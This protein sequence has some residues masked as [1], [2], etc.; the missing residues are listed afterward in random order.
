[1]NRKVKKVLGYGLVSLMLCG[2]ALVSK[3]GAEESGSIQTTVQFKN[4]KDGSQSVIGK[5][6]PNTRLRIGYDGTVETVS[7]GEGNYELKIPSGSAFKNYER[8]TIYKIN[9]DGNS[10]YDTDGVADTEAPSIPDFYLIAGDKVINGRANYNDRDGN[11]TFKIILPNGDTK[12]T[13]TDSEGRW[14]FE[15]PDVGPGKKIKIISSDKAGN[16]FEK[17]IVVSEVESPEVRKSIQYSPNYQTLS[18]YTYPNSTVY[19]LLPDGTKLSAETGENN[20]YSINIPEEHYFYKG[21][22][23]AE[24]WVSK[25]N[26]F[27]SNKVEVEGFS[28]DESSLYNY[29][30]SANNND[31]HIKRDGSQSYVGFISGFYNGIHAKLVLPD[32]F[33]I[34]TRTEDG[35]RVTFNIPAKHALKN[36]EKGLVTLKS[37][38]G[39]INGEFTAYIVPPELGEINSLTE[40]SNTIGGV[41]NQHIKEE[42]SNEDKSKISLIHVT[43]P[44]G[45]KRLVEPDRKG[46][47]ILS[48]P[49]LKKG[50]VLKVSTEDIVGNISEP[51]IIKVG[52]TPSVVKPDSNNKEEQ[53]VDNEQGTNKETGEKSESK[54]K[55][56]TEVKPTEEKG[57]SSSQT[58]K[59]ETSKETDLKATDSTF[60]DKTLKSN[61][62]VSKDKQT[63]SNFD[64]KENKNT[65]VGDK[66]KTAY[67]NN[68]SSSP[69]S[70]VQKVQGKQNRSLPN[71]GTVN[72][73]LSMIS[74]LVS[75]IV[76]SVIFRLKKNN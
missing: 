9:S 13:S 63:T 42:N 46:N 37:P 60:S 18:G 50:D 57:I 7:D 26:K 49:V 59:N 32:G 68:T 69:T 55:G 24:V 76:G 4:H 71:T 29:G 22:G 48:T 12:E 2:P 62:N 56:K 54:E 31:F 64:R 70:S 16:I 23:K 72:H 67:S 73:L 17:E 40:G 75:F 21:E 47:W 58:G 44:N 11:A 19:V 27:E 38:G 14:E 39:I 20:Y 5:T 36:G 53:K 45:T 28:D 74:G 34:E 1:M 15:L 52:E 6:T 65:V 10:R 25:N 8:F 43:L 30:T 51:Y 3:V 66:D 41:V 33:V 61:S 35:G